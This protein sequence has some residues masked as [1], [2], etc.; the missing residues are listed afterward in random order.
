MQHNYIEDCNTFTVSATATDN[1]GSKTATTD[2]TPLL[3]L[4]TIEFAASAAQS[5]MSY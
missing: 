4:S 3:P 2:V 1:S 5:G